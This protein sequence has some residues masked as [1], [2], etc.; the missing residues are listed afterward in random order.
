MQSTQTGRNEIAVGGNN[1]EEAWRLSDLVCRRIEQQGKRFPTVEEI[2]DV[3][4]KTLIEEGHA[5]T[6]KAYILY[7]AKRA[8]LRAA[9]SEAA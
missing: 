2:Q 7:R 9:A 8:E 3:V 4:E 6:A 1:R 5:T